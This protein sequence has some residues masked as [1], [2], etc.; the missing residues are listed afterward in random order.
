MYALRQFQDVF[1]QSHFK[2][3]ES[4]RSFVFIFIFL[5][6]FIIGV[7][8]IGESEQFFAKTEFQ[9]FH[10]ILLIINDFR[11][12]ILDEIVQEK[13]YKQ[14]H[15]NYLSDENHENIENLRNMSNGF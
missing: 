5:I 4:R 10:D 6:F 14:F 3:S 11:F 8:I 2:H 9:H 7:D 1:H 13:S 12:D 15:H